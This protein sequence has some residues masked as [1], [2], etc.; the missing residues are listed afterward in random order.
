[1]NVPSKR[2]DA[3]SEAMHWRGILFRF[4][5]VGLSMPRLRVRVSSKACV[6]VATLP[7]KVMG[8]RAQASASLT[9]S[10]DE[11]GRGDEGHPRMQGGLYH[12]PPQW[13]FEA[14][15]SAATMGEERGGRGWY[16]LLWIDLFLGGE[17]VE[18]ALLGVVADAGADVRGAVDEAHVRAGVPE[19]GPRGT[20]WRR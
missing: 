14:G 15:P 13:S 3:V 19:R 1:M 17:P 2:S 10:R 5:E 18:D 11:S 6:V 8:A 16:S 12:T 20:R 9:G 7:V 4:V